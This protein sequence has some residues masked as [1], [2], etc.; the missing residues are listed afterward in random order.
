M[1]LKKIL[2]NLG[3]KVLSTQLPPFGGMA[4]NLLK[5]VLRLDGNATEKDIMCAVENATPEQLLAIKNADN[6][7]EI[8]LKEM[9]VD[10]LKLDKEDRDSA[11][12]MQVETKS[13]VPAILSILIALG[14]FAT[15]Y[16]MITGIIPDGG[17]RDALLI[18]VG[19]LGASFTQV[20]N[21]WLGSSDGSKSKTNMIGKK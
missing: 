21:F 5:E 2:G 11:R 4:A 6:E 7:F 17:N 9:D 3:C 18:L 15:L 8:K 14:F 20:V 1:D 12:S 19:V 13:K 10:I 16:I